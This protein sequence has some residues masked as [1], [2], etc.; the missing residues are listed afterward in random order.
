MK[1]NKANKPSLLSR[2]G[3]GE[4]SRSIFLVVGILLVLACVLEVFRIL[5]FSPLPEMTVEEEVVRP[6]K[7]L[8]VPGMESPRSAKPEKRII[9]G[10]VFEEM[11][12]RYPGYQPPP[13]ELEHQNVPKFLHNPVL[14]TK[15]APIRLVI[16]TDSSCT[17]CRQEVAYTLEKIRGYLNRVEVV[18]KYYPRFEKNLEGGIFDQIARRTGVYQPYF[19]KLLKNRK[20]LVADDFLF[21]LEKVGVS[22]TR[23]RLIMADEMSRIVTQLEKDIDQGERLK[24]DQRRNLP[25]M[26]L[27]GYRLGQN[28]LPS[29]RI[30]S[31]ID[32]IIETGRLDLQTDVDEDE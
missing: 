12:K 9:E 24:V 32:E 29:H 22:L 1:K 30:T 19:W 10:N 18:M 13:M 31:Y 3:L 15:G 8:E 6:S 21:T 5:Y 7:S 25:V 2:L 11:Y 20:T 14:G 4:E 17:P 16:F 28:Y 23:L 27:N 26:Y